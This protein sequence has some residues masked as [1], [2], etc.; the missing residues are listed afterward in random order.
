MSCLAGCTSSVPKRAE[1]AAA[2]QLASPGDNMELS[3]P[4]CRVTIENLEIFSEKPENLPPGRQAKEDE[5][6]LRVKLTV[7]NHSARTIGL[8]SVYNFT[9]VRE[10]NGERKYVGKHVSQSNREDLE[11]D[12]SAVQEFLWIV[13][14]EGRLLL[15]Y[16]PMQHS[17]GFEELMLCTG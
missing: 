1:P 6:Y 11:P 2:A 16:H 17:E 15:Q 10:V 14:K 3:Y 4:E 13:P 12:Q 5:S 8:D 7:E 9:M